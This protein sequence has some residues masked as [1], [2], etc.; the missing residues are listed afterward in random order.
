MCSFGEKAV[1][2]PCAAGAGAAPR[3]IRA[4][5]ICVIA[6]LLLAFAAQTSGL[7]PDHPLRHG[8]FD[9]AWFPH[10]GGLLGE[11]L[12]WSCATL[13]QRVGAHIV[14]VLLVLVGGLML[15]GTSIAAF[16]SASGRALRR[17]HTSSGEIA[18]TVA[19]AGRGAERDDD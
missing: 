15:T 9:P 19:H 12:Y 6:G 2:D 7:G 8:Y 14:A 13:F 4:G 3:A 5:G 18:R 11:T 10:H 16:L 17:A 1:A